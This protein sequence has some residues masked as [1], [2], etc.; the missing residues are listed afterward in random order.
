MLCCVRS[1]VST[2][3]DRTNANVQRDTF[4]EK[5]A[6]C[7]KVKTTLSAS[8]THIVTFDRSSCV[9]QIR[10]SARRV[11]TTVR[12]EEWPVR[13]WLARTCASARR[14]TPDSPTETAAWVSTHIPMFIRVPT[15]F[16][17]F[18]GLEK[19]GKKESRVWKNI[20]VSRLYPHFFLIK[21]N[22]VTLYNKVH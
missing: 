15:G 5:T 8:Q 19:Y 14:D 2:R 4:W 7:A 20:C 22:L 9:H 3:W 21:E 10:T 11:W 17:D 1:A 13:I 12:P 16:K 6:G 18:P